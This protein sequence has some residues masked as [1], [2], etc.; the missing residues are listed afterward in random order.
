[1]VA[2]LDFL[3]RAASRRPVRGPP[4]LGS[5]AGIEHQPARLESGRRR[6]RASTVSRQC[7]ATLASVTIGTRSL[8]SSVPHCA[9]RSASRPLPTR[10][11]YERPAPVRP[12]S[13][14]LV[15]RLDNA[16]DRFA[17][18]AGAARHVD[19]RLGIERF[20]LG[21][22][23]GDD[24]AAGR[25][26]RATGACPCAATRS[27]SVSTSLSSHT[28]MPRCEDQRA[29]VRLRESAAAGRDHARP[30]VHQPRDHAPLAVAEIGFAE[31]LEDLGHTSSARLARSRR[32]RRGTA[33]PATAA[34]L[35]PMVLLPTPIMPTST[36]GRS[37]RV[38]ELA[39]FGVGQARRRDGHCRQR[40]SWASRRA[41]IGRMGRT[42][43]MR[44]TVCAKV[45]AGAWSPARLDRRRARAAADDRAARRAA[46]GRPVKRA[47]LLAGAALAVSSTLALAAAQIAAAA[48]LRQSRADPHA[49]R[50]AGSIRRRS[51]R[52]VGGSRPVVQPLP[53]RAPARPAPKRLR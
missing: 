16:V 44:L 35:R 30:A 50:R 41:R 15:E 53:A 1:M 39:D 51:R 46:G 3:G 31:A 42:V 43:A 36:T 20:A 12:G 25:H 10:T 45:I 22:E 21:L 6:A 27:T 24:L 47:A 2:A 14:P 9:G 38:G 34:S 4:A 5:F 7:A 18:R 17:V 48:E 32:R 19:R 8:R 49:A 40:Y 33:G 28:A 13:R 11:S 52:A 29:R 23:P 37:I 26:A